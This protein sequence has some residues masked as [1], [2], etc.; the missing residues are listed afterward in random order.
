M[1]LQELKN[2]RPQ[3]YSAAEYCE[4][5]YLF[6]DQK[7]VVLDN[8]KDYCI[9]ALVNAV[10]HLGTVAYKLNEELSQQTSEISSAE[11]RVAGLAQR[12]HVCQEHTNL[13]GLERHRLNRTSRRR[14][15]KHYVL[16]DA[17]SEFKDEK[18]QENRHEGKRVF[19]QEPES[20]QPYPVE[21]GKTLS[22]H[23]AADPFT[24][25]KGASINQQRTSRLTSTGVPSES[26]IP[27]HEV[28][29]DVRSPTASNT[30]PRRH[31]Q[32]SSFDAS[33]P[34]SSH[35]SFDDKR[36]D[37]PRP[38]LPTR[39]KSLLS[40]LLGRHRTGKPKGCTQY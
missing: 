4:S 30:Q 40:S 35:L 28:I 8:L 33:K 1:A 15:H 29:D 37:P 31:G 14:Y 3:L 20:E 19:V 12:M 16:P 25:S 36:I 7:Q 17:V 6:N 38:P 11:L 13:R 18:H 34:L 2:L 27:E 39:S 9:K 24:A 22:W 10:D 23:L 5:S 32:A 26:P 21:T